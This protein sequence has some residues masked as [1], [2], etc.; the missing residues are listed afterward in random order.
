MDVF[1]KQPCVRRSNPQQKTEEVTDHRLIAAEWSP[2]HL[3]E[4]D[5]LE[6]IR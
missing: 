4:K 6:E 1:T 3:G 2:E 5:I